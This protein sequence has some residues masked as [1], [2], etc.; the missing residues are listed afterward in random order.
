MLLLKIAAT[1]ALLTVFMT[2]QDHILGLPEEVM[3][4]PGGRSLLQMIQ[5][6]LQQRFSS[7]TSAGLMPSRGATQAT[8]RSSTAA[9]APCASS[10]DQETLPSNG[11]RASEYCAQGVPGSSLLEQMPPGQHKQEYKDALYREFQ[12]AQ[13]RGIQ[14]ANAA[15]VAA[16][17]RV[18]ELVQSGVVMPPEL[19]SMGGAVTVAKQ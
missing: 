19:D 8:Q 11:I 9:S 4:S 6:A 13:Q 2:L 1:M 10:S 7:V 17:R 14:D 12:N 5:P 16:I 3:E 18:T 15:A